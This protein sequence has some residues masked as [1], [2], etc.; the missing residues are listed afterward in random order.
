MNPQSTI[1]NDW[2][3][4]WI[5][6]IG[7]NVFPAKTKE[8]KTFE[9]WT[10]WQDKPIPSELHEKRKRNGDYNDG[11]AVMTGMLYKGR[12]KGKYLIAIDLDN[13]KAVEEFCKDKN[14]LEELKQKTLVEQ[15]SNP[16]KM[17][18]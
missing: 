16:D 12:Y 1:L 10:Q 3:D 5:N 2:S 13:K 14:G 8:K 6:E 4:Y 9:N 7:A 17:H 15:T 18:I 11:I